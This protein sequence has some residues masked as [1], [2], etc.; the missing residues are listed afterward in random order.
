MKCAR[1]LS[2]RLVRWTSLCV[3]FGLILSGLAVV[4][5]QVS[6]GYGTARGSERVNHARDA[7]VAKGQNDSAPGRV[8]SVPT[9]SPQ[10]GAPAANLPNADDM[11]S[12]TDDARRNSAPSVQAAPPIPSTMRSRRKA[13]RLSPERTIVNNLPLRP[14]QLAA[15]PGMRLM[16]QRSHHARLRVSSPMRVTAA[17][18]QPPPLNGRTNYALGSNG[19]VATASS[20]L[21][22]G[23]GGPG[24][25]WPASSLNN[26]ERKGVNWAYGGGWADAS[27]G[28]F[29]DWVQ[30]DFN[31]TKNID[32]IDLFTI[33]DNYTSPAEPTEAMTFSTYG[34][35][36]YDVQYWNGSSWLT[37][38]GGSIS[39]NN[40]VWRK[41]IF[42][43][44][45]T[46]S[47]R[48]NITSAVDNGYSRMTEVEA[49][50][51][52]VETNVAAAANGGVATASSTL[53]AGF[54]G[55][56]TSWPASGVNN[57]DRK[58]M[59][60]GY[61]GGWADASSG[62]FP[63]WIQIDFNGNKTISEIDLFTVQDNLANP[64]EPT[65]TMTFTAYG[66]TGYDVEYWNG[67]GW[68]SI[69]EGQ[70]SGNN[71]VWRRISFSPITTARIRVNTT[72]AID[73]GYSRMTEIEAWGL[74]ATGAGSA[75]D[76]AMA[77]LD[78]HN[79]TGTGGEDLLSNNF[80]WSL[81]LVGLNGRGLDLGLTLSYN[82]LV[83]TRSGDYIDFDIDAGSIAPGFRL[84][85]PTIEGPYWNSQTTTN[86]YLL[87]TP[88]GAR[89]ELRYTGTAG[90]YETQDSVHLQ[91]I[92]NVSIDGT[93]LL[94]PTDGSRLTFITSGGSW[95][96]REIKDRNGNYITATYKSWGEIETV[97]DTLNRTLTFNYDGNANL[98]SITQTWNG[99][100]HQWATFG[101]GTTPIGHNFSGLNNLGP[102]STPI[103]VLAQVGFPDGSHYNFEY[104]AYGIV[105]TIHY[106]P[107]YG[108]Q[109]RYTTYTYSTN[110][111]DAPRISQRTDWAENWNGDVDD[112][113]TASEEVNTYF[114]H[115]G[116]GACR[117]TAP[118]GTIHKE[119]YGSGWQAGLT[120]QSEIWSGGVRQKWTTTGYTQDNTSVS[121][122]TNPRV[123][124][125]NIY[126]TSGNRRRTAI[127]YGG[128]VNYSLPS[129]VIE[130]A[131][132]GVTAWRSKYIDYNLGA[133]Y[134]NRRIIGL[135]GAVHIFDHETSTYVSKTTYD[136]DYG[137]EYFV[138]PGT[139]GVQHDTANYG[140]GFL[141][142][143]GNLSAVWHWDVTDINN[144]SKA[145]PEVRTAYNSLGSVYFTRDALGHQT[146]LAYGDSF[147]VDGNSIVNPS[148]VTY[149][150]PT[151]LTDAD[152]YSSFVRYNYDFGAVTRTQGP[153]PQGQT[154]G[155]IQ[156]MSYDSAG[157]IQW[158]N[159]VNNGAWK[160]F[161]Y[162]DHGDAVMSQVT[163]NAETP[164]YWSITVVDGAD[165]TRLTGGDHPGSTRGY[166]GQFTLYDVMGRASQQS[167]PAETNASWQPAGDDDPN[168]GGSGWI[169][170]QQTYDWKGRPLVTTNPSITSN[171][172]ETTT[173]TASY[174]G[175]GC[176]GG[177]VT[178]LTDEVGRQQSMRRPRT[179]ST[180]AI[181]Q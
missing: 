13:L 68:T 151:T 152:G 162:A 15:E 37:V 102:D 132:D 149:A 159:K 90:V 138:G 104:N 95:R 154:Q 66:V 33:Q 86:F 83:W 9:P 127:N 170:T 118:D 31:G 181:R 55:P 46:T 32:E 50:G 123:T 2:Q 53:P 27:S 175:C 173:K 38:S 51:D 115:D 107:L 122:Q 77:R 24:T 153:P 75:S 120:A 59:N 125:T 73:N 14:N 54:S 52:A 140:T 174:S 113:P 97:T 124:E 70:I 60:W 100:T 5:F 74:A 106:Y 101:W 34:V 4:P 180:R 26:G 163:I 91:L 137:G 145:V 41:I 110:S 133:D 7:R 98:N 57:G 136:Y 64:S 89:V 49:W 171:P 117:L 82:S 88:S 48:V 44:I 156:T 148:F 96:C 36:G 16:V 146:T 85:F 28:T 78:P 166:R 58:G 71:N 141:T 160:F 121:Y 168:N 39:G 130:Y 72:A 167:N 158:L 177:E 18:T 103:P 35:S 176:A 47:I 126:D 81:P 29:P 143:R 22:P 142:G 25:Y 155:A 30:I 128:S 147:S 105:S 144:S 165:R 131:A 109:R 3:C 6:A 20:T 19:G 17:A 45:T 93:L 161:A 43:A 1:R 111:T 12:F 56:G 172:A 119:Y 99:Q 63:D 11:R 62:T 164:A 40:K 23:S 79:R 178:T 112:R 114:A 80:N 76:F 116:D 92:D 8:L 129:Q 169:Y 10:P 65:E 69:T 134:V 87:V 61:G 157:R 94:R 84:G 139:D 150:Y 179:H 135:P 108:N 42:A 67:S 21:A